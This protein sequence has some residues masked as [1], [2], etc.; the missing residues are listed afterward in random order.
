M[1]MWL[2]Y[3][4]LLTLLAVRGCSDS[5]VE[6]PV[7]TAGPMQ[8]F[9]GSTGFNV[10]SYSPSNCV[11]YGTPISLTMMI[12]PEIPITITHM[13]LKLTTDFPHSYRWTDP[14]TEVQQLLPL[15]LTHDSPPL[16]VTTH[17]TQEDMPQQTE[18]WYGV[19]IRL[20]TQ[21]HD[22]FGTIYQGYEWGGY[23][24]IDQYT[25]EKYETYDGNPISIPCDQL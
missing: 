25:Y 17:W 24:G 19:Y 8:A 23:I 3:P 2:L 10:T 12:Q 13:E 7:P 15:A 22:R 9:S 21:Y 20:Y 5:L 18:P 4:I 11:P 14:L 6:R 16:T 1:R